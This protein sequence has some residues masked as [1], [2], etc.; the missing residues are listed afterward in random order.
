M[1]HEMRKIA[2]NCN[3]VYTWTQYMDINYIACVYNINPG[4][5]SHLIPM[6]TAQGIHSLG[7]VCLIE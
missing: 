4:V 7:F 5:Y 2:L 1:Y 6:T 3:V